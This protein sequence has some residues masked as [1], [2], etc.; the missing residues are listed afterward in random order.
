MNT[1][2]ILDELKAQT[3]HLWQAP[4]YFVP[5]RHHS[6]ACA[7][8]L[9]QLLDEIK[10]TTFLIEGPWD[11]ESLVPLLQHSETRPPVALFSQKNLKDDLYSAYFPLC[12][13]SPEWVALRKASELGSDVRFIDLPYGER[14]TPDL[15]ERVQSLMTE[16]YFQHNQ[17]LKAIANRLGCRDS[18]E[19]WDRLFEQ[20]S[21][22]NLNDWRNFFSDVF[23]YCSLARRDY[24]DE[25]IDA[26]GDKE[27]E[28]FM[29]RCIDEIRN[30]NSGACVIVT[31]GFHTPAL[32][33]ASTNK[34]SRRKQS[35]SD[36]NWLIRYSFDQ[37]DAL[38]GYSAGMPAPAYYQRVWESLQRNNP[39]FLQRTASAQLVEIAHDNRD[40]KLVRSISSAE[41]HAAVFQAEQLARLRACQ[42]PGRS[43]VL[44]AVQS[45][46]IKDVE[47]YAVTLLA[48]AR[49][50]MSGDVLG[51]TPK[52]S[53][54]PPLLSEAWQQ[55]QTLGLDFAQTQ[56]KTINL[57]LYR[58]EK[59]REISRYLHLMSWI[60]SDLATWQSGPDFVN[61]HQ[62]GLMNEQ[63]RYAWTP[64]VEARLLRRM[65]DGA[66]LKE[67]ALKRLSELES[68]LA[69]TGGGRCAD[70]AATLLIRTCTMGLHQ[71]VSKL[72]ISLQTLIDQDEHLLSL[73]ACAN[74][75]IALDQGRAVLESEKLAIALLPMAHQCWRNTLFLLPRL[76]E[77]KP[78]DAATMTPALPALIALTH[79]LQADSELL[80][81]T[82]FGLL[83]NKQAPS[84]VRGA[85]L[86]AMFKM[87]AMSSET[88]TQHL[89]PFL[90]V[91]QPIELTVGCLHGLTQVARETL[92]LIPEILEKLNHRINDWP[93]S[94]FLTLLPSL[95]RLFTEFSPKE[96]NTVA[97]KISTMN[98][99]AE[100]QD[101]T[102]SSLTLSAAELSTLTQLDAYV[103]ATIEKLGLNDW[104]IHETK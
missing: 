47:Q 93:E 60:E 98:D 18:N 53:G 25:V 50:V 86:G 24:E 70:T 92:W 28:A 6:P 37:L 3:S 65:L 48:D 16:R 61:S 20:R 35:A 58:K 59:H 38:N 64:Q 13:Y 85:A 10:P 45:C 46:Y 19:S 90:Q 4:L 102:D 5:I 49:R 87:S 72:A 23:A 31:G 52:T 39:D 8:A 94:H 2:A 74:K 103:T 78:D 51:Q 75:L 27:R 11:C 67:V 79:E 100:Y 29:L 71:H 54:Q 40:Q 101:L 56:V 9:Q 81:T 80:C 15:E 44:D 21:I 91:N 41:V 34:T 88:L 83:N 1:E 55:G 69:Q 99:F 97:R 68:A 84:V 77:L 7:Y 43:E 33:H 63:W 17:Y 57:E 14:L 95:R 36:R 42:G 30:T 76:A 96:L 22:E 32:L 66:S 62:M 12:E 89:E 82:L 104:C 26:S 73:I